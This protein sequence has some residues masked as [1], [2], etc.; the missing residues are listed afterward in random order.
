MRPRT[1]P[2][3][4][5]PT[6]NRNRDGSV[7]NLGNLALLSSYPI[8]EIVLVALCLAGGGILKGATGAGAPVLAVPAL[9]ALFDVRFAVMVMLL[10][11]LITNSWQGYRF[12]SAMPDR[13]FVIMMLVGGM[14]GVAAGTL[15]LKTLSPDTLSIV[16]ALAVFGYVVLRLTRPDWQ[17][18]MTLARKLALPAGLAAGALQ[19]AA[20]LSAPVSITF[21]NAIRLERPAYIA[22]ISMFFAAFSVVQIGIASASGLLHPTD[23]LYGLFAVAPIM[24][25]MPLGARLAQRLSPKTFDRLIL[26]VL[27]CLAIK[28]L[29]DAFL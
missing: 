10:P 11:N 26:I 21:L 25:A 17:L 5:I 12:F 8:L 28:L 23:L 4:P 27:S 14:I 16:M 29:A 24:L 15:A 20:G 3:R 9:A 13:V 22:A 1:S 7:R 18:R 6:K 2:Y 19:G